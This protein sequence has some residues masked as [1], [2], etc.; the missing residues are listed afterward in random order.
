M[1]D[2]TAETKYRQSTCIVLVHPEIDLAP[3]SG[4]TVT[5]G[6]LL[7]SGEACTLKDARLPI[8][9]KAKPSKKNEATQIAFDVHDGS[10]K[11]AD[12]LPQRAKVI[13]RAASPNWFSASHHKNRRRSI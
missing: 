12:K 1:T 8:R 4:V 3:N 10:C 11:A 6:F 2:G 13:D 9:N 5:P 7:F